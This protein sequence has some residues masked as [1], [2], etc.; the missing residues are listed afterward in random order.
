MKSQVVDFGIVGAGGFGREVLPIALDAFKG[1]LAF[2]ESHP[3]QLCVSGLPVLSLQ[4]FIALGQE[5]RLRFAIAISQSTARRA[6]ASELMA[7]NVE[8]YPLID[9][10]AR[11]FESAT[12]GAGAILS[13]N[14]VITSDVTIGRFFHGNIGSYVAH[15]C[16]IGDFVTFA[17]GVKCNGNVHI[18]DGAYIGTGAMIRPGTKDQPRIIGRDATI[19]M[20]SVVLSDVPDGATVAGN[21]AR[22]LQPKRP[23][24]ST[25][26]TEQSPDGLSE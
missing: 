20:G 22:P 4:E 8:P 3:S 14:T 21:P 10:S 9:R 12:M 15:D 5:R 17:P 18:G 26:R 19:G 23:Q 16:R 13:A 1:V 11:V 24:E 6:I 25:D 7:A 2:V